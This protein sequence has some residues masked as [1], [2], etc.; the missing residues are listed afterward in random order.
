MGNMEEL[1]GCRPIREERAGDSR[2]VGALP[3]LICVRRDICYAEQWEHS[4]EEIVKNRP[5]VAQVLRLVRHTADRPTQRE[6][7]GVEVRV[8]FDQHG[9]DQC[10]L[11]TARHVDLVCRMG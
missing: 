3:V 11:G 2:L 8:L 1:S 9:R 10:A 7:T 5:E 4:W 6:S